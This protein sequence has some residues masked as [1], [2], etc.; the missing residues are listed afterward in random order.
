MSRTFLDS[1]SKSPY[2]VSLSFLKDPILI[3]KDDEFGQL[4]FKLNID[5]E[6]LLKFY[7]RLNQ[8]SIH[9]SHEDERDINEPLSIDIFFQSA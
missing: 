5:E 4:K 7:E 8:N 2:A 6:S 3:G 1:Y 9:E